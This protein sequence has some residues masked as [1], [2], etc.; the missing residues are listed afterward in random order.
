MKAQDYVNQS[1]TNCKN[2]VS[3]LQ[4]ALQSAEKQDNKAKIQSAINSLN[5]AC[6]ELS[7]YQD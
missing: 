5:S 7:K 3:S 4:Q 6:Q 1:M 2:T